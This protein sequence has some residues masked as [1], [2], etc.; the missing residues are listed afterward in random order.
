MKVTV[1]KFGHAHAYFID[2][3][4]EYQH[5]TES[6]LGYAIRRLELARSLIIAARAEQ[7]AH[8]KVRER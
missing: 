3:A 8:S 6:Q 1:T 5:L 7:Q 2:E 4:G